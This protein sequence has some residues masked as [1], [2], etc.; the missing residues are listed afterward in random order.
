M[1]RS[2]IVLP[3]GGIQKSKIVGVDLFKN[4]LAIVKREATLGK[5]GTYSIDDVPSPVHGT[6]WI[7]SAGG[8]VSSGVAMLIAVGMRALH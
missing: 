7:D 4:G 8:T 1:V 6:L 5:P 2:E 3:P